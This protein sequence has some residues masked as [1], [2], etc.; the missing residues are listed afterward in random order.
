[1]TTTHKKCGSD[2]WLPWFACTNV[3]KEQA[4]QDF[5]CFVSQSS[6]MSMLFWLLQEML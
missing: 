1:M 6:V 2:H 3:Q 4:T 5:A